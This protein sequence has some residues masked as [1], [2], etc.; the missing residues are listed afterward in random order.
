[1]THEFFTKPRFRLRVSHVCANVSFSKE[2]YHKEA[3]HFY[4]IYKYPMH[5]TEIR[6]L[7]SC[8]F[9][10]GIFRVVFSTF[11]LSAPATSLSVKFDNHRE[12]RTW[13]N[14]PT[15]QPKNQPSQKLEAACRLWG[16]F[17]D[18]IAQK[19]FLCGKWKTG[20]TKNAEHK[21]ADTNVSCQGSKMSGFCLKQGQ[22]LKALAAYP[23]SN[24]P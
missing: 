18:K 22:G 1:M 11:F 24:F 15:N 16:Y 21:Q 20:Q 23:H 3:S 2:V 7:S 12:C 5:A 8:G 6:T 17:V 10:S 4:L 13:S 14:Q 9:S 19:Y